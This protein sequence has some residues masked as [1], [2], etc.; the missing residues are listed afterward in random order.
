MDYHANGE[1]CMC[2]EYCVCE[3]YCNCDEYNFCTY[4]QA[5]LC[6]ANQKVKSKRKWRS[7][8][9]FDEPVKRPRST[10][11]KYR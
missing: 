2:D 4:P 6:H 9:L 1:Y 11:R 7:S 3:E 8:S 10:R 5:D